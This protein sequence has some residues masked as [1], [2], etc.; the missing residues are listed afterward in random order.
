MSHPHS[1]PHP[2]DTNHFDLLPAGVSSV[3][4]INQRLAQLS[5]YIT[6]LE[7]GGTEVFIPALESSTDNSIARWDGATGEQLKD[8]PVTLDD[9]GVMAGAKISHSANTIGY[10]AGVTKTIS[11]P[12]DAVAAGTDRNLIISA[13][14]GTSDTLIEV[15]GLA[16]GES[17]LLRA[18]SGHTI[19]VTHNSGSA[20]V[21][22]HLHSN[23]NL[24]A[25]D[26][27]NPL[28]LTLVATNVL[29]EDVQPTGGGLTTVIGTGTYTPGA[30]ITTNS[31]TPVDIDAT[32]V[33]QTVTLNG[34]GVVIAICTLECNKVTAGN[35]FFRWTNGTTHSNEV[36]GRFLTAHDYVITFIG[37]FDGLAAG[38]TTFKPQFRSSD[39]NNAQIIGGLPITW[40]VVELS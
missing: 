18:T 3:T 37:V 36:P 6:D 35:M 28:R 26:E 39:A 15:T 31:T 23:T 11:N 2:Q 25:L 20:T 13:N 1:L 34:G 19:A 27:H 40:S 9:T 8:S 30:N 32:N 12:G 29:V 38:S 4:E 5:A 7:G 22:I 14:T 21:K 24:A 10:G 17:V 33:K 16:V